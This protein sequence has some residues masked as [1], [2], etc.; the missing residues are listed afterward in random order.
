MGNSLEKG[1]DSKDREDDA[2]EQQKKESCPFYKVPKEL[3][4][5]E[6]YS[7]CPVRTIGAC[8][9]WRLGHAPSYDDVNAK[10]LLQKSMTHPPDSLEKTVENIVKS[11]EA[12]IQHKLIPKQ[13]DSID[14]KHFSMATNNKTPWKIKDIIKKGTYCCLLEGVEHPVMKMNFKESN[15]YFNDKFATGFA[16]EVTKVYSGPPKVVFSWRHWAHLGTKSLE[17]EMNGKGK[18]IELFGFTR[19]NVSTKGKLKDIEVFFDQEKFMS[20]IKGED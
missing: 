2:Q 3:T 8:D 10:Y 5:F 7:E 19:A 4:S 20:D 13:I 16:W 1:Q 6:N 12:E 14:Q 17:E 11:W 9:K 18:I 15:Q